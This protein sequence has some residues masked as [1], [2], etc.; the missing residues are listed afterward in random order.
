M[1]FLLKLKFY[2]SSIIPVRENGEVAL[3]PLEFILCNSFSLGTEKTYL[4]AIS[5][6]ES[7]CQF[8]EIEDYENRLSYDRGLSQ[9]EL[10]DINWGLQFSS[11]DLKKLLEAKNAGADVNQLFKK[12]NAS[13]QVSTGEVA[14][15]RSVARDYFHC[16][17]K[18]GDKCLRNY[19][20]PPSFIDER[21]E[22]YSRI[23][24]IFELPK[25]VRN[26]KGTKASLEDLSE[27]EAFME[28][29]D[30]KEIWKSEEVALRN[31]VIFDL[32]FHC[33]LRRGEC[34]S[35]QFDDMKTKHEFISVK[36]RRDEEIDP[37]GIYA[38]GIKTYQR[39]VFVPKAVWKRLSEWRE[40]R[41]DIDDELWDLGLKDRQG[42][43]L[44]VA[45][46]RR[47]DSFGTPLSLASVNK[48][49]DAVKSAADLETPGG[50]HLLRHL[51]AMRFVRERVD[52]GHDREGITQELR[53]QFGWAPT[54]EMPFHYTNREITRRNS[55]MME[56][57]NDQYIQ[58][59]LER[60]H[61][62]DF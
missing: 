5:L 28:N 13:S 48:A 1:T 43:Y 19:A 21:H 52:A 39:P 47:Q 53:Q 38:P 36:D 14:R 57:E 58:R 51:S 35:L 22:T 55:K 44:F 41:I 42:K 54:S 27:L 61:E 12:W 33:G 3:G 25:V 60:Q 24:N 59:M 49:F 40:V 37:R 20:C 26:Q 4:S 23:A 45:L 7:L 8:F 16:L 30:A 11:K 29:Y 50:S 10:Y 2:D 46:D 17:M 9:K 62:D 56:T 31:E 6:I 32:Q 18:N 15:R 34:L